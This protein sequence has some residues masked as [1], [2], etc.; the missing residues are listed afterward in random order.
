MPVGACDR[1]NHP[2]VL[3][4]ERS[5]SIP[6]PRCSQWPRFTSREETLAHLCRSWGKGR[7]SDAETTLWGQHPD[8]RG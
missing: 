8:Y 1:C 3:E 6:Y 2:Y 7:R 4:A 5:P